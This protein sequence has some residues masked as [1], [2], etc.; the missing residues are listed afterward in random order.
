[1]ASRRLGRV[2]LRA[3]GMDDG[4]G[5]GEEALKLA[6]KEVHLLSC[7]GSV[8]DTQLDSM[9]DSVGKVLSSFVLEEMAEYGQV[10]DACSCNEGP[11]AKI[12]GTGPAGPDSKWRWNAKK[13]GSP[14][15]GCEMIQDGDLGGLIHGKH[16]DLPRFPDRVCGN[17]YGACEVVS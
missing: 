15:L 5:P 9:I 16:A 12:G 2:R 17:S 4:K 14:H 7:P 6:N 3:S 11:R 13:P 10:L 8:E 1:M